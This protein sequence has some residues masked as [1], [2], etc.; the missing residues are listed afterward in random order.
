MS[1]DESMVHDI[2]QKVMANM[3]ITGSVEGMHGVFRDMNDAIK[4]AI[5]AQKVVRGLTLDQRE[6][7]ISAIRRKRS[8]EHTSELQSQR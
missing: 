4:A 5:E 2:V 1:V 8:E 6:K 3:Q 7:I